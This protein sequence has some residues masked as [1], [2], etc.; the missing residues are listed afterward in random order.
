MIHNSS[1]S[2]K[3]PLPLA[4]PLRFLPRM[5]LRSRLD[6][7]RTVESIGEGCRGVTGYDADELVHNR[8]VAYSALIF[9]ADREMVHNAIHSALRDRQHFQV[10]YR[11]QTRQGEER[12]VWE[13]GSGASPLEGAAEPSIVESVVVDITPRTGDAEQIE[14]Q[15]RLATVGRLATGIAHDFNNIMSIISLYS[16]LLEHQPEHPQRNHFLSIINQQANHASR[17]ISQILDYSRKS[18]SEK[19]LAEESMLDLNGFLEETVSLL[20]RTLPE[21]IDVVLSRDVPA[22]LVEI[23][24]TR[25][26]QVV[27][28]LVLNARDAMAEGGKLTIRLSEFVL[29]PDVQPPVAGMAAGRWLQLEVVDSGV[30]ISSEILPHIF[31]P[32]FTTK[33]AGKGTGLGLA[34][35]KDIIER[36][37]GR[38]GVESQP[39]E[40]A[41]FS[42]YLPAVDSDARIKSGASAQTA[43]SGREKTI[44]IVEDNAE[45]LAALAEATR[46]LGY[47]VLTAAR[48]AEALQHFE[49]KGDQI[50]LLLTDAVMPDLDGIELCRRLRQKCGALPCLV[51]SGYTF[52]TEQRQM[53]EALG[54]TW[55]QKPFSLE[56]LAENLCH[57]I[58][59]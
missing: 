47:D 53:L 21:Q 13:Q 24:P 27:I 9:P 1:E 12:W 41:T 19:S 3:G 7:Q 15:D 36:V 14:T 35:V 39:G 29:Q 46:E 23:D 10:S 5:V 6:R 40:G 8:V 4:P 34:Q 57:V 30:G 38:V 31:E 58:D 52:G 55:L 43:A 50:D 51:M 48:G 54:A 44:L 28:N 22:V 33:S 26:Q 32:F 42:V 37:G 59:R 16:G 17:L 11:I 2:W 45:T 20:R 49:T 18:Q 25:L 56:T